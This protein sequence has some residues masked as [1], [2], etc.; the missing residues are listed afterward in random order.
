MKTKRFYQGITLLAI[1][2]TTA[3][4]QNELNEESSEPKPGEKINMT[5]RATQGTG[6]QTRTSYKDK[7]GGGTAGNIEVKWEGGTAQDAPVE[8][9]K[10]FGYANN[11]SEFTTPEDFSSDPKSL[12]TDGLSITFPG[13][14][15]SNDKYLAIYPASNCNLAADGSLEF[16]FSNQEQDCT[17]GQE[18]AHLKKYDIMAGQAVADG[19]NNFKFKHKATMLRFDLTLPAAE[20]INKIT[21]TNTNNDNYLS[22]GMYAMRAGV[23][24]VFSGYGDANSISLSIANHTSSTTL[25][26]YMMTSPCDLSN[27]ELTVTVNTASGNTY[28]GTLTTEADI[29]LEAGLCYT[30][31]PTLTLSKIVTVPPVTEGGLKTELDKITSL[32][33][34]QTELVVTGTV[35]DTDIAALATFLKDTKA[36]DIT[37][38]DL[39]GITGV[40][41]VEGLAACTK[42]TTVILPNAAEAIGDNAFEGCTALT[43]VIQN[44]TATA[45]NTRASMPKRVKTVGNAA[46]K[47]CTSMTE[48]FLH[49]GITSVGANAFEGCT[50]LTALV[51]EGT[52]TVSSGITLGADIVKGLDKVV[53]LLP[54]I[55]D[56]AVATPYKNALGKVTFYKFDGGDYDTTTEENKLSAINYTELSDN[57]GGTSPSLPGGTQLGGTN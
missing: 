47:N 15:T 13:T 2:L 24:I 31:T 40:T 38:L 56:P 37:T 45:A 29:Y 3:A 6:A 34:K 48:M 57:A 22:T 16:D 51:F 18:M 21:L 14:V 8:K 32:D 23:N 46:F 41:E 20:S 12:S 39:S 5:I 49:D 19:T 42:I 33:P 10:V 17:A 27:D 9:I 35:D 50:A 1:A 30:L 55:T 11:G 53:I 4:C 52:K 54:K 36:K 44:E 7:L 25:K 26:A 28:E 43:T